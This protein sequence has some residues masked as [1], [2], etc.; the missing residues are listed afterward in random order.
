MTEIFN[1]HKIPINHD[2]K[3]H[4][5]LIGILRRG[6]TQFT[7][8]LHLPENTAENEAFCENVFTM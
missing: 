5:S 4:N 8:C 1:D 2:E 7:H 3:S 6:Q